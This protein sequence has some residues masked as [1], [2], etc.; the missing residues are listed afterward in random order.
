MSGAAGTSLGAAFCAA[1]FVGLAGDA[2]SAQSALP[3]T[4]TL[5]GGVAYEVRADPA[6]PAAA[7]AL[8]FRAPNAGFDGTPVPGLSRLAALTVVDSAPITGTPLAQ[9][10]RGWGGRV[11]VAAYPDSVSVTA[12]V[13]ADR[14]ADAVRA[15]TRD[16][17]APVASAKGM[18]ASF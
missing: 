17:F 10:V 7:V 3:P 1:L 16:F 12:L 8:W 5:T 14:A 13:P 4:G 11:S 6:Q 2:A 15:L 18:Q 9:L